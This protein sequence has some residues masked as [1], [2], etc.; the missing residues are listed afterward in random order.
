MRLADPELLLLLLA[1]PIFGWLLLRAG[2]LPAPRFLLPA[3]PASA[4]PPGRRARIARWLPLL[5]VLAAA[6]IIA[7]IARPQAVSV[8]AVEPA[9]GIDVVLAI[10]A[11]SSMSREIGEDEGETRLDAARRVARDFVGRRLDDRVG[12]VM[13]QRRAL[14]LSPLT[15]DLDAVDALLA[16][17]VR[18]GLLVDGTG[19]GIALAESANLLRASEAASRIVVLL[20][21][22][23]NNVPDITPLQAAAVARALGIRVYTVGL[24]GLER[25]ANVSLDE[26]SLIY[27]ADET[28]GRYFRASNAG[29][30]A[31]AYDEIA[32]L[33]RDFVGVE[34]RLLAREL[35]PWLLLAA[36]LLVL[37]ELGLRAG[38]LRSAP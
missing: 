4:G 33:E 30:L 23:Q 8:E 13:F 5:R 14:V 37:A 1:L 15:L 31:A 17:S 19:I 2:R 27:I 9:E 22:G 25:D 29:E 35:A 12:L 32:A 34:E 3:A 11:S 26:I 10:D 18:S 7:A 28:G 20:T 24:P 16:E 38:P 21:D 36:V 6:L